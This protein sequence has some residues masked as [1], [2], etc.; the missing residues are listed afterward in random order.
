MLLNPRFLSN[1]E[2]VD[3]IYN[4]FTG[5]YPLDDSEAGKAA[6]AAVLKNPGGYVMKPQREG[7]FSLSY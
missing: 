7:Y 3:S 2:H 5:L 1:Q 4:V 6:L